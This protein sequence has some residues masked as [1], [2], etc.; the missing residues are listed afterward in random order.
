MKIL[1]LYASKYGCT[2]D[3]TSYLKDKIKDNLKDKLKQEVKTINLKGAEHVDLQHYD[4]IIIGGSIYIG[5]IQKE[6]KLFCE[7]NLQILLTKNIVLFMC[8]TTPDQESE[9]FSKNF[10]ASLRK[11]AEKT[12]NMGGELRQHK[13]GFFD[14]KITAMV[15]KLEPKKNEI[16]YK[17]IDELADF[18]NKKSS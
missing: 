16:L 8:C 7:Q 3:C 17:N 1:I 11:H 5:K 4:W 15:S 9:F 14:K 13:M 6:V 12:V 2:E 18:L 10:P